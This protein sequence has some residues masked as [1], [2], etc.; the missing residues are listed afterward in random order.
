MAELVQ[1]VPPE[2]E[3]QQSY[4]WQLQVQ[5]PDPLPCPRWSNLWCVHPRCWMDAGS[6]IRVPSGQSTPT[7]SSAICYLLPL[8][9]QHVGCSVGHSYLL[10][11]NCWSFSWAFSHTLELTRSIEVIMCIVH[12]HN[13]CCI[14]HPVMMN[15]VFLQG[16]R[17]QDGNLY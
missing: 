17:V 16:L 12:N 6:S 14:H 8:K 1:V 3:V 9:I 5:P 7:P 10:G 2:W 4:I 13:V 11:K 15:P